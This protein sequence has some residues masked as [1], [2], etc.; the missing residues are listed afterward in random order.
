MD[1]DS[2][3]RFRLRKL[4][5]SHLSADEDWQTYEQAFNQVHDA[6]F[7][8]LKQKHPQLTTGDL[9]LASFLRL[10]LSSKEIASLLGISVRGVENKRYRL[11]KKLGLPPDANLAAYIIEFE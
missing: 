2:R 10:N 6:F 5:E 3:S 4:I 7:T 9:R 8:K 11:R 1:M